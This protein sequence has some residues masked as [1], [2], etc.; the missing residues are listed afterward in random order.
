MHGALCDDMGLVIKL[1]IINIR[2]KQYKL[3]A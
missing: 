2:A 3:F 1:S